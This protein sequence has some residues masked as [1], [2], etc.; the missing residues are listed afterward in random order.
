MGAYEVRLESILSNRMLLYLRLFLRHFNTITFKKFR[1]VQ[2][3]H[4]NFLQSLHNI[5][6]H[7][8]RVHTLYV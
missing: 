4:I 7:I 2:V 6:Y 3:Q 5:I 1:I 8:F